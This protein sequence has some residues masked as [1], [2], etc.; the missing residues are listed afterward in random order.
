MTWLRRAVAAL[1]VVVFAVLVGAAAATAAQVM[2]PGRDCLNPPVPASPSAGPANGADKGPAEPLPGDPFASDTATL[3]DRYGYA[4]YG[5]NKFETPTLGPEFAGVCQP[6]NLDGSQTIANV[7]GDL[8]AITTA[9]LVRGTRLVTDGS[10]GAV[11][12][13]VQ[14]ALLR[15][16]GGKLF[17]VGST[18]TLLAGCVYAAA[19]WVSKGQIR[20]IASWFGRGMVIVTA[21]IACMFYA[22][23]VGAAFDKGISAAFTAAAEVTTD[24]VGRT[25]ADT[26]AALITE[27]VLYPTWERQTFGGDQEAA[28]EFGP[29]LFRAG[30]FTREEQAVIDADP[31]K[32]AGMVDARREQYKQAM[33]DLKTKHPQA[34]QYAAGE[35]S[36]SQM[37][38]AMV[39]LVGVLSGA[40]FL[41]WCLIRIL[42]GRITLSVGVGLFPAVAVAAVLPGKHIAAFKVAGIVVKAAWLALLAAFAFF[43]FVIAVLVPIMSSGQDPLV[44]AAAVT[45][46]A[47]AMYTVLRVYGV[48]PKGRGA[49]GGSYGPWRRRA[50]HVQ[51]D[52]GSRSG[53]TPRASSGQGPRTPAGPAGGAATPGS[54]VRPWAPRRRAGHVQDDLGNLQSASRSRNPG[55]A[56]KVGALVAG[57]AHPVTAA[58]LT[59]VSAV[60]KAKTRPALAA[61]V[62]PPRRRLGTN[63]QQRLPV[64]PARR[65]P[66]MVTRDGM[67]RPRPTTYAAAVAASRPAVRKALPGAGTTIRGQVVN[68]SAPRR[69]K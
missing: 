38:E 4:G 12:D 66:N 39:G 29:R 40:W 35:Q 20:L 2:L 46:A 61:D 45:L 48:A 65:T 31:G 62:T 56:A 69:G 32:A 18:L 37:W 19:V 13:P 27:K 17:L 44:R 6:F 23:G 14:Q 67:V 55:S 34:Y 25:P 28:K 26:V 49:A 8:A 41:G 1:S 60:Q 33:A 42:W 64:A 15:T 59:A 51:D 24:R 57:R 7:W 21:A 47:V 10:F 63:R 54:T 53:S 50:G 36:R 11:W 16:V 43:G 9:V 3:Y 52:T 5:L 58:A 30:T 22:V 68:T